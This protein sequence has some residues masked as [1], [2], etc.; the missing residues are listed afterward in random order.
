MRF[1][2]ALSASIVVFSLTTGP[3][4]GVDDSDIQGRVTTAAGVGVAGATVSLKVGTTVVASQLTSVSGHYELDAPAQ[5]YTVEVVPNTG[6]LSNASALWIEVPRTT[7]L[8]FILTPPAP[9]RVRVTGTLALESGIP[10]SGGSVLFGGAGN[11]VAT[12]GYFSMLQPAGVT[13]NWGFNGNSVLG[14]QALSISVSGGPRASLLQDSDV[15]FVVPLTQTN[16]RVTDHMGQPLANSTVRLNVGGY[17]N[18]PGTAVLFDGVAPFSISWNAILRTDAHGIAAVQRP[19]MLSPIQGVLSVT[20]PDSNWVAGFATLSIP[21]TG[22]SLSSALQP[23]VIIPPAVTPTPTPTPTPTSTPSASPSP[24]TPMVVAT[25]SVKYSSGNPAIEAIVIPIDPTS[26]VN[27]GNAANV[28]GEYAVPKPAGFRGNWQLTARPQ[29]KLPLRDPLWFTL[30]GGDLRSWTADQRVDFTIP[31]TLYRVRVTDA[32][33]NPIQN[34]RVSAQA[35]D[36]DGNAARV[37]ILAGESEFQGTWSGWDFTG[38]DGFAQV[39]GLDSTNSVRL[40]LTVDSDP[41]SRFISRTLERTSASLS[42]TVIVL[43]TARPSIS[44]I[45]RSTVAPGDQFVISG[46]NLGGTQR[47]VIGSVDQQFEAESE[48]K[49]TVTVASNSMSGT[50]RIDAPGSSVISQ[51]ISVTSPDL[52]VNS[53]ALPSGMVGTAIRTSIAAQGGLAP[54]RFRKVSGPLPVGLALS[55]SG[56]VAGTP[57]RAQSG[58][59]TVAV[60][61]ARGSSV[62]RVIQW[63][64]AP[65]PA[66]TPGPIDRV[67]ASAGAERISL[68]WRSPRDIGGND[69]TAYQVQSSTDGVTWSD[70]I[71]STGTTSLGVSF[72]ATP[73]VARWYRV[74]AINA[75]GV[76]TYGLESSTGPIA[77]YAVPT[78]PLNMQVNRVNSTQVRITWDAPANNN[79]A[80][81]SGYRVR[82]SVDGVRWSTVDSGIRSQNFTIRLGPGSS[83]WIQVAAQNQAGLGPWLQVKTPNL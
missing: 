77:A 71:N 39:P 44:A 10:I 51:N 69:I 31:T 35:L 50:L 60:T 37:P 16:V 74:A 3:A 1:I 52:Q 13:G 11:R 66:T 67:R 17:G 2:A 27:G 70:L 9:G 41:N 29:S 61:D 12:D 63:S 55:A 78:A 48:N 19:A 54:Y 24:T 49:I 53:G 30:V 46:N 28:N 59:F 80:A 34:A 65:K 26:R 38:S 21:A 72:P 15:D 23:R 68:T 43:Q 83:I 25:G 76:G 58:Q 62:S 73:G 18:A 32:L 79:G 40:K 8:D 45:S 4:Q 20:G 33:G 64:I 42:E 7:S 5:T 36:A 57:T 22:G 47:V 14:T 82:T 6:D 56:E 75:A 81:I